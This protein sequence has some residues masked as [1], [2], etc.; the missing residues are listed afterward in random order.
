VGD[1][2]DTPWGRAFEGRRLRDEGMDKAAAHADHVTAGWTLRAYELL[3]VYISNPAVDT[4]MTEDV[5]E[6]IK[7]LLPEPP[8]NQSWGSI[9]TRAKKAGLIVHHGTDTHKDPARH[10]GISNVWRVVRLANAALDSQAQ[11]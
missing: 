7:D 3:L 2:F 5:R 8:R 1:E 4:F 6:W 10:R 9:M 11:D